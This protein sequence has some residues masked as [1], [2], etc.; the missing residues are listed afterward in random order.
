[1][2]ASTSGGPPSAKP[3]TTSSSPTLDRMATP[4]HWPLAVVGAVVPEGLEGQRRERRRRPASSPAGRRRRAATSASHASTARHAGL[5]RVDVPGGEAHRPNLAGR[6]PA[7]AAG[8]RPSSGR[9]GR[10]RRLP[11]S[12][13]ASWRR[14][15]ARSAAFRRRAAFLAGCLAALAAWARLGGRGGLGRLLRRRLG[16]S[17]RGLASGVGA[18]LAATAS[19]A[20][21]LPGRGRLAGR[22]LGRLG[23]RPPWPPWPAASLA[24][25]SC[26]LLGAGATGRR[27]LGLAAGLDGRRRLLLRSAR[28][29][30][31]GLGRS[32]ASATATP[33]GWSPGTARSM[34][35]RDG[36]KLTTTKGRC[37]P[38][39]TTSRALR[40][41]GSAR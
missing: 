21:R 15:A 34:P 36:L 26:C 3:G 30:R 4:F 19:L 27:G 25:A 28:P 37:S 1:M 40:G 14:P 23:R 31:R 16:R 5:Q 2:R 13:P 35:R 8:R 22:R 39:A 12:T 10:L 18:C 9:A 32:A 11:G 38:S 33:A 29:L 41:A 6:G 17:R 24:C 7:S 20:G